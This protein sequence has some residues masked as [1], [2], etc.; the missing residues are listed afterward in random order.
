MKNLQTV[1]HDFPIYWNTYIMYGDSSGLEDGEQEI[2][3]EILKELEL[4]NCVDIK[5][6]QYFRWDTPYHMPS[7]YGGDYATYVFLE[8]LGDLQ[9]PAYKSDLL[10]H[11]TKLQEIS[12]KCVQLEIPNPDRAYDEYYRM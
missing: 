7:G 5:D 11:V 1:E 12:N 3:D 8:D 2:I 6:N 9:R 4:T 10:S